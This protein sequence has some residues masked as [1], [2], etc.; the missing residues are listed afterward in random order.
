MKF[1]E[2]N[3]PEELRFKSFIGKTFISDNFLGYNYKIVGLVKMKYEIE[4]ID[5]ILECVNHSIGFDYNFFLKRLEGFNF[6]IISFEKKIDKF[7]RTYP[8]RTFIKYFKE[9]NL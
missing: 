4:R 8:T 5:F 1:V 2:K 6:E 9:A 7:Y 3:N